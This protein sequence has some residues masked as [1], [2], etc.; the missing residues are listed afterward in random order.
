MKP[1][2]VLV[3]AGGQGSRCW[4]FTQ[5]KNLF[6]FLNKPF[7]QYSVLDILPS[8]AAKIVWVANLQNQMEFKQLKLN[9]PSEVVIQPEAGGMAN[10]VITA[11]DM[12]KDSRLLILIADHLIDKSIIY[13]LIQKSTEE[14]VFGLIAGWKTPK[15]FPGGYLK[16]QGNLISEIIEKPQPGQEPSQY[17]D[18][19]GNYFA[20]AN[21][22]I[23]AL[24]NTTSNRDDIYEKSLS[25][26]MPKYKFMM[27]PYLGISSSIKY[28][29][30]ILDITSDLLNSRVKKYRGENVVIKSNVIIEGEVYLGD[31]VKVMENS[32]IVGPAFIGNN[33]IIGNNCMVRSTY[34]GNDC[35]VGFNSDVARSYIGDKC[36]FHSNY[37]GDSVL[38][39]NVSMGSG[40]V[41]A[42]MRLDEK[43]ICSFVKGEKRNTGLTKLGAMIGRDVRI[44]VNVSV[45]PGIKIGHGSFISSGTILKEDVLDLSFYDQ[46]VTT[47]VKKNQYDISASD[48]SGYKTKI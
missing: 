24:E 38:E 15:Y 41:L 45:M 7:Y 32:K 8:T 19:S 43:E 13:D 34:I 17:V 25:S 42:N 46:T 9:I 16:L 36:W 40:A 22:L 14:Q 33:S 4:P 18:V 21:V 28:P 3:L 11:K 10:A 5:D 1:L 35:V 23:N 44:G 47:M 29:W 12:I 20:D 30:N 37:I 26:L 39:G 48:R 27:V 2:I 31:N 6:P